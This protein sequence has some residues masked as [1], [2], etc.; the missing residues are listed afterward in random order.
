MHNILCRAPSL[1]P[2][3]TA[4]VLL[5]GF[6][7]GAPFLSGCAPLLSRVWILYLYTGSNAPWLGWLATL[8]DPLACFRPVDGSLP[9]FV[10]LFHRNTKV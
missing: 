9:I 2:R 6:T 1:V 4:P 5:F 8:A 10:I 3:L 7:G